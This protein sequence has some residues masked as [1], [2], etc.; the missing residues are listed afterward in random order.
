[1]INVLKKNKADIVTG[2]QF[3]KSNNLFLKVIERNFKNGSK[4][5]WAST[6]NVFFKSST[7]KNNLKF[8]SLL[9]KTGGE[10]QLFFLN[11]FKIG[12]NFY[13]NSHAPVYELRDQKRENFM[14]FFKRN[15]RYGTSSII[16][17]RNLY[18]VFYGNF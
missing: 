1:M 4:I 13:W 8:S 2:P 11:L 3:S 18:G 7:I 5:K 14:W 16:I 15:L 9:N 6:N 10:D 17:Y 12:K